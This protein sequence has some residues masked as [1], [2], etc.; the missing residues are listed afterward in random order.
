MNR[1]ITEPFTASLPPWRQGE[2]MHRY[3]L[4]VYD[5]YDR[6]TRAFPGILFE[7]CASGGARFDPG[8]LAYAPQTWTSDNTDAVDRLKIQYGTSLAYPVSSMG[9]H[10]SAVPNHQGGRITPLATRAAVAFFGV[11]GYELDPTRLSEEERSSVVE[12]V[13][14]YKK[15]RQVIQYGHFHRLLSPFEGE[16][17]ETAWMTVGDDRRTALVGFYE[18]LNHVNIGPRRLRL[19]GLDPAALYR[20]SVWPADAQPNVPAVT[21]GG[22]VLMAAGL[23]IEARR[24]VRLAGRLPIEGVRPGDGGTG[25]AE[26]SRSTVGGGRGHRWRS[27]SD[28]SETMARP[29]ADGRE[30]SAD[31]QRPSSRPRR[32]GRAMALPAAPRSG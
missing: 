30:S 9:A 29:R 3:I 27:E 5:L 16:G 8:M 12:Q 31:A 14:F 24:I 22:D 2:F 10:V 28:D 18:V 11:F 1:N 20:V 25:R 26:R 19:R 23:V 21:V 4:G 13:A 17:N 32:A 15:W 6:L 7:S